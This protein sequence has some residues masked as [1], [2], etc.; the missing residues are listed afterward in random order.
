LDPVIVMN[1]VFDLVIVLLAVYVNG[2]KHNV[3][4]LWIALAFGLFAISYVLTILGIT[5]STILI[6]LRAVGY[7]SVIVGLAL[8]GR[9]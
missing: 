4:L 5:D 8:H 2:K 9:H 6:P 3:L 7:L 1:L